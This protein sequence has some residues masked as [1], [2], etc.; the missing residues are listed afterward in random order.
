VLGIRHGQES[1]ALK[2]RRFTDQKELGWLMNLAH[3]FFTELFNL[4]YWQRLSDP[5]TMFKVFR[6]DCIDGLEFECNRFDFDW[7]LVGKLVRRGYVPTEIPVNYISRSFA[8]GKKVALF[9]DPL[10]WFRACFK[11][12]FVRI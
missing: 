8:A 6:R 5:F 12:R 2:M 9:R 10:T 11:Y 3:V 4:V 1:G 7:E